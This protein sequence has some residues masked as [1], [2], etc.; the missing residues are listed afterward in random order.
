MVE[1]VEG[2]C[3]ESEW[4]RAYREINEFERQLVDAGMILA[5]FWIHI[6]KE[7]QLARFEGRRDTP[8][9]AWKL[10]DE[11]WRNRARWDDYKVAVDDMLLRTSTLTAPWTI[12]EGNDK[13]FA[14]VKTLRTLVELLSRELDHQPAEPP[15][16]KAKKRS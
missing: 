1:R 10:T 5:K 11:D 8:Y 7:E 9:K 4:R 13:W 6:S 12:V 16:K 14:R 15:V 2:F 3:T